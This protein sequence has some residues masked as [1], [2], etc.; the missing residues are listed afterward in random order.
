MTKELRFIGQGEASDPINQVA[1]D[2]IAVRALN[3]HES[4]DEEILDEL[5]AEAVAP[6][7]EN[8]ARVRE[9]ITSTK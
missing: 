5:R 7:P 2:L 4:S 1:G 6:T 3:G 9:I 8:L